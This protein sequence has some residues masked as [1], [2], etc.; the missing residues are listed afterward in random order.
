M[1]TTWRRRCRGFVNSWMVMDRVWL[2]RIVRIIC[3]MGHARTVIV[4]SICA[5]ECRGL[6]RNSLSCSQRIAS[7]LRTRSLGPRTA[8]VLKM[9]GLRSARISYASARMV[10]RRQKE[11]NGVP[12]RR[13]YVRKPTDRTQLR[14]T[15]VSSSPAPAGSQVYLR[16]PCPSARQYNVYVAHD[17]GYGGTDQLCART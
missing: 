8:H 10:C 6:L 4:H 5:R 11:Q 13:Q 17:V 14:E 7:H 3:I 12:S 1:R 15:A 9:T 16:S 2:H